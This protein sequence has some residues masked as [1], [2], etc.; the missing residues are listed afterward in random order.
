MIDLFLD[1]DDPNSHGVFKKTLGYY[2]YRLA[3][4]WRV[5]YDIDYINKKIEIINIDDQKGTYGKD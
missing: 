3:S 1:T 2:T 5:T 4:S